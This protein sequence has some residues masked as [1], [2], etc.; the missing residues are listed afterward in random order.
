VPAL[1]REAA[2]TASDGDPEPLR[3]GLDRAFGEE[4]NGWCGAP[5]SWVEYRFAEP[6]PVHELRF[7]FDS[8]LNRPNKGTR[9]R[10]LFD[11]APNCVPATMT[12]AFRIEAL[13]D[14]GTWQTIQRVDNNYQRL[15]RLPV[16][17]VTRAVRFIAESTWGA[18]TAHLFAWDVR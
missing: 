7:T 14:D 9:Y 8:D 16:D 17:V 3:N 1:S 4:D 2:L 13:Q 15:V 10:Y 5:G 6:R 11:D 12:R 18:E